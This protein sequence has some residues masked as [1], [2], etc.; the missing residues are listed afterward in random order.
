MFCSDESWTW[1]ESDIRAGNGIYDG[2]VLDRLSHAGESS[3]PRPAVPVDPGLRTADRISPPV[4]EML[5]LA[6]AQVIHTPAGETVLD[7]G[8][9]H[10]GWL[11]FRTALPRGTE[12]HFDF[13]E[14]LQQGNFYNDNYRSAVGGF[15]YRSDGREETVCQRFTFYGFRYV[16]VTGWPGEPDATDF[17][18]PVLHT[19]LDRTGWLTTGHKGLNRLYENVL[20]GQRSN[21]LSVPTDCPQ[22]DER[23]G[24]TGDAQ[25]FAPTACF[26]MDC[27]AFYRSFLRLLRLDQCRS[28]GSVA[29]CI[30]RSHGF[31]SCAIWSDACALIPETLLH[32]SGRV[33]E[34]APYYPM[35]KDWVDFVAARHPNFLYEEDQLGDWLALDGVTPPEL[36]GRHGRCLS[37]QR[38]LDEQRPDHRRAGRGAGPP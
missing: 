14:V 15:T 38:V 29:T 16:R 1:R 34:I 17:D 35:M 31:I 25:V 37:G 2:E 24:W 5:S 12:V 27:R 3:A 18:S 8:Q 23:L 19:H 32:F 6:V 26:N 13:G 10:T 4:R 22:R 30:P 20:W 36:Q 21:F 11:R 7:F 9:N 28:G 33:E